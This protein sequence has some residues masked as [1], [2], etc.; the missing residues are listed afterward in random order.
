MSLE[1]PYF[2]NDRDRMEYYKLFYWKTER[3]LTEKQKQFVYS[4]Y[5]QEQ[6]ANESYN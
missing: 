6:I 1:N 2:Y 4:M 3:E 5:K